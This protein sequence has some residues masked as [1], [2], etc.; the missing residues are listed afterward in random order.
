[1]WFKQQ[2]CGFD[3]GSNGINLLGFSSHVP[4]LTLN[5]IYRKTWVFLWCINYQ[6]CMTQIWTH[7]FLKFFESWSSKGTHMSFCN[8]RFPSPGP[9]SCKITIYIYIFKKRKKHLKKNRSANHQIHKFPKFGTHSP[10]MCWKKHHFIPC[11][12]HGKTSR[13]HLAG[14]TDATSPGPRRSGGTWHR[15]ILLYYINGYIVNV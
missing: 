2:T 13:T 4:W 10:H 11:K 12:W 1:M 3:C 15:F 8:N 6:P 9:S 14:R 7:E 5:I